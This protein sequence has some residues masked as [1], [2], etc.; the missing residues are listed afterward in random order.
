MPAG[1]R[2]DIRSRLAR[3]EDAARVPA[4]EFTTVDGRRVSVPMTTVLSVVSEGLALMLEPDPDYPN[5]SRDLMLLA[6]VDPASESSMLG[7]T[8][9]Q[10]AAAAREGARGER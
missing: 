8:L 2:R 3:L 5:A 6:Q 7:R 1:P 10:L 9:V 4:W